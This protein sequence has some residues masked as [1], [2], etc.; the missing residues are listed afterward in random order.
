MGKQDAEP[1]PHSVFTPSLNSRPATEANGVLIYSWMTHTCHLLKQTSP[2]HMYI[3]RHTIVC[4]L[5]VLMAPAC[6]GVYLHYSYLAK[7]NLHFF[8][9]RRKQFGVQCPRGY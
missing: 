5:C 8:H 1:S 2:C 6:I 7:N 9:P 4:F 3:C